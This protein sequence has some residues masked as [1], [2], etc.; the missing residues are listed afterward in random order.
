MTR[1]YYDRG[2]CACQLS[3]YPPTERYPMWQ[4][5][6]HD[7]EEPED[8]GVRVYP[9]QE[10]VHSAVELILS[11]ADAWKVVEVA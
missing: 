11:R 2:D 9:T 10:A 7:A 5:V 3:I 1:I 8:A 6:V 4:V